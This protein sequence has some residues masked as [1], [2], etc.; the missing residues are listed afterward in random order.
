MLVWRAM[1]SSLRFQRAVL[2]GMQMRRTSS[3][4]SVWAN[5]WPAQ[6]DLTVASASRSACAAT[7]STA[8]ACVCTRPSP[9]GS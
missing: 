3:S 1:R 6:H 5:R 8:Y 9:S 7:S 2:G 4:S